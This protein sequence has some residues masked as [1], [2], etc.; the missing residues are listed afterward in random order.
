MSDED[1]THAA[2]VAPPAQF[3]NPKTGRLCNV[4]GAVYRQLMREGVLADPALKTNREIGCP[5]PG[6]RIAQGEEPRALAAPKLYGAAVKRDKAPK[7]AAPKPP[8]SARNARSA[9]GKAALREVAKDTL[10]TQ[11]RPAD[12][13][14]IASLVR[15]MEGMLTETDDTDAPSRMVS[16]SESDFRPAPRRIQAAAAHNPPAYNSSDSESD[17]SDYGDDE[18]AEE[19]RP[20]AAAG[21]GGAVQ[22]R[23][24][25]DQARRGGAQQRRR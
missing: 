7:R 3:R 17:A 23:P 8:S 5:A 9:A 18:G 4:G 10:K 24:G 15:Q 2:P 13:A 22:R 25:S 6:P 11:G 21:G 14:A 20:A 16:E 19:L 12:A 1:T